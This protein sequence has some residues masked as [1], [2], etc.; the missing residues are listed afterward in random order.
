MY[1]TCIQSVHKKPFGAS[2]VH[3]LL[4]FTIVPSHRISTLAL[5][6]PGQA[7]A[8]LNTSPLRQ[9]STTTKYIAHTL[10]S[11]Q[12]VLAIGK[13]VLSSPLPILVLLIALIPL[14]L[15][16][17]VY[18]SSA[19][20]NLRRILVVGPAGSGKTSLCLWVRSVPSFLT[21]LNSRLTPLIV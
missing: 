21:L 17:V 15:H 12:T 7:R 1:S 16:F 8:Q 2:P 11:I 6:T 19:T 13:M 10:D 5:R 14:I 18:R 9:P 20:K 4:G 3:P